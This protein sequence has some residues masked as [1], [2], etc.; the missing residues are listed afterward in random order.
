M[1]LAAALGMAALAVVLI[2]PPAAIRSA[3]AAPAGE[4]VVR[5]ATGAVRGT[6]GEVL[7]FKGIPYAAPPVG[8]LRWRAPR[9]PAP[10]TGVR[11]ATHFGDDCVQAPWIVSSGQPTSEDCLT[12]NVW[13]PGLG[14]GARRP[15]LVFVYGGAFIGGTGAYALYDGA[16]L[17]H[18]GAVVVSLNYRV[19]IL[20]FLAHPMLSAESAEHASG[21]Y[22]LLDQLAALRWVKANIAA[23]GGDPRRVTVF[24]ESAGAVSIAMLLTSPLSH[25]LFE[26]A[27]IQSATVPE[28]ADRESAEQAGARL[29]TDIAVL[30]SWSAEQL[31]AHNLDFFPARRYEVMPLAFPAP[32]I[33]G[34]VLRR[35]PRAAFAS[36][37]VLR[38]P[39]IIG[40]NADEG[41]MFTDAGKPVTAADYAAWVRQKFGA[42]AD[43][44]LRLNPADSDATATAAMS[45]VVG[46]EAFNADSRLVARGLSRV[47]RDTYSYLFSRR[48]GGGQ[49]PA[50]HSE[51]LLF[52]FGN[53]DAPDFTKHSPPDG[54]DRRLSDT[55]R[56]IWVRFAATGSPN[57]PGLPAWPRYDGRV[58]PYLEFGDTIRAG[59]SYRRTQLDAMERFHAAAGGR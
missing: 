46:D 4:P 22:G 17:A 5:T 55:M 38:V 24:G 56:R 28:L 53:F 27:I 31:L 43:D 3:R 44:I 16:R 51:E 18:D 49:A 34:H 32:T 29:S 58:D 7:A 45:A 40:Y 11:D 42:E 26:R 59:A 25:G 13:T 35:Q 8:A 6:G 10:W 12:V 36:G 19:G 9:P 52:V 50:T 47:N 57:G 15:V 2:V 37:Q 30:R 21:N 33:D 14:P 39:T 1:K 41:R 23:F 48:I 54:T 20:G